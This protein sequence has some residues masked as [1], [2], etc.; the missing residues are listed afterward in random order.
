MNYQKT[1]GTPDHYKGDGFDFKVYCDQA[2]SLLTW[3]NTA[4]LTS[5]AI[6]V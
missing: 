2:N 1:K 5:A 4:I 3:K 6:L